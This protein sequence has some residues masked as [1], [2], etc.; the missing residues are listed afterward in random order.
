LKDTNKNYAF[1][2]GQNLNLGIQHLGWKLDFERFRIYLKE[3]YDVLKAYYFIGFVP[4]NNDLY[5]SLQ[6]A[7]YTLIYKPTLIT[8]AG[9]VKGNCDAE[10]VLQAMID[11]HN[12]N[13]AVIVTGDGDFACLVKYLA[14]KDKLLTV[15]SPNRNCSVLL[16][17]AAD[18]KVNYITNELRK[19]LELRK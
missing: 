17:K 16:R 1:I 19:K 12:Y 18:G 6:D 3:K 2:D 5:T 15:I 10:L 14:K 4:T 11:F 9:K 7:G 8:K 13:N